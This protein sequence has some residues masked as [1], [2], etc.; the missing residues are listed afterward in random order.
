MQETGDPELAGQAIP[1]IRRMLAAKPESLYAGMLRQVLLRALVTTRAPGRQIAS[2]ADSALPFVNGQPAQRIGFLASVAQTLADRGEELPRALDYARLA[3]AAASGP[4]AA[5]NPQLLGFA[6]Q[7]L[8]LVHYHAGH[9]DSSAAQFAA[10]IPTS[11]DSGGALYYLGASHDKLGRADAAIDAYVRA[12]GAF[13]SRDTSALEPLRPLWTKK[14]GSLAGMDEAIA[15]RRAESTRRVALDGARFEMKAPDWA[16]TDLEGKP[17][18]WSDFAGKV[19]VIDF[20]GSWCGPCRAELPHFE[21]LYLRYRD[22]GVAFIGLNW[23]RANS[24]EM[25]LKL[26]KDFMTRNGFTFPVAV[27]PDRTAVGA[28]QIQSFPTVFLVDRTGTVRYRN[29]GYNEQISDIMAAQIES[30]LAP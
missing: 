26:A 27:D 9:Y 1:K 22:R 23:E 19:V 12:L 13:P 17:V 11:P 28:Y 20:W 25:H 8:A 14:H 18:A 6:R 3:V 15:A 10:V 4:G 30:L 21:E 29:I 24:R 2:A 5:G 16:L 7:S